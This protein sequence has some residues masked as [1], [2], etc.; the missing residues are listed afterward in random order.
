M[1]LWLVHKLTVSG[2]VLDGGDVA[3]RAR[4]ATAYQIPA[5]HGTWSSATAGSS[6]RH[7]QGQLLCAAGTLAPDRRLEEWILSWLA[8]QSTVSARRGLPCSTRS[9]D[10]ATP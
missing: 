10:K 6:C 8:D 4:S 5:Q 9:K 3:L 2:R 7:L 1:C